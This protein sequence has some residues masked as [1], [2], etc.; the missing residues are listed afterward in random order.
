MLTLFQPSEYATY[1]MLHIE[2]WT[3]ERIKQFSGLHRVFRPGPEILVPGWI[4]GRENFPGRVP[5][6]QFSNPSFGPG[7]G[8]HFEIFRV[9][10]PGTRPVPILGLATTDP[11]H[12]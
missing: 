12:E 1:D 9:S 11:Y 10:G 3:V 4:P 5:G 2:Q 6:L 8:F 7:S